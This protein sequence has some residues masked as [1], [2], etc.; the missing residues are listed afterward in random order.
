[1]SLPTFVTIGAMKS[2]TTSLHDYLRLHPDI[3]MSKEKEVDFFFHPLKWEKGLDWYKAQF[4]DDFKI[5]GETSPNYSKRAEVAE[6][7]FAI[8]PNVKIIYITRDPVKRF[9]S[10]CNHLQIDP[11]AIVES[12][13]L[14]N[15]QS[16]INSLY[17]SCYKTF[18]KYYKK[19]QMLLIKSEDLRANQKKVLSRIF[20]FVGAKVEDYNFDDT[21]LKKENHI[22]S[23]KQIAGTLANIGNQ[24]QILKQVKS[25]LHLIKPLL[26]PF[27]NKLAYRK[28]II[29]TLSHRN[30]KFLKKAFASEMKLLN[31]ECGINYN[32]E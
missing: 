9:V 2:G 13:D 27:W 1:M 11:N 16:F 12:D 30:E 26:L 24:N 31:Q 17:Y 32:Y 14:I 3:F 6:R 8:I 5:R 21:R 15:N 7:M 10:E 20:K 25:S 18:T 4:H 22:T 28:R 29:R 19:E 23:E